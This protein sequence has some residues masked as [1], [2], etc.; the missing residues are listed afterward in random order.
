M[1]KQCK[2][3]RW[4]KDTEAANRALNRHDQ[5]DMTEAAQQKLLLSAYT[6]LDTLRD[7]TMVRAQFI[8]LNTINCIAWQ[9]SKQVVENSSSDECERIALL[10]K[11]RAEKAGEALADLGWRWRDH[12]CQRFVA[13]GDELNA[14]RASVQAYEEV[15]GVLPCG[16]VFAATQDATKMV[17]NHLNQR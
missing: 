7:G 13:T 14:L 1:K 5:S 4:A 6:L 17:G 12:G 3:K 2:R 10:V 9:L 15:L 16:L 11:E 8:R